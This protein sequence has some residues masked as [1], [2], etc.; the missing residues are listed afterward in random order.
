MATVIIR[1][2]VQDFTKWKPTFDEFSTLRREHGSQGGRVFQSAENPNAVTIELDWDNVENARRF[3][4]MDNVRQ[5]MQRAGVQ[6]A[7]EFTYSTQAHRAS[8]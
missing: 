8:A 1:F 2:Q 3:Y 5:A 6:G 7:P 4:A